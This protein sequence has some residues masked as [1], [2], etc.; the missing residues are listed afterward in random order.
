MPCCKQINTQD[1]MEGKSRV[2]A[3]TTDECRTRKAHKKSYAV[4]HSSSEMIAPLW[5]HGTDSLYKGTNRSYQFLCKRN[6]SFYTSHH[7]LASVE[8]ISS[9]YGF[10]LYFFPYNTC[11]RQCLY[12]SWEKSCWI[13]WSVCRR[14]CFGCRHRLSG[15]PCETVK[16]E[17]SL[18]YCRIPTVRMFQDYICSITHP[19]CR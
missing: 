7:F 2:Y 13:L 4:G 10:L 1:S 5:K 16:R 17:M 18:T 8:A 3:N 14:A 6:Y 12:S 15:L 11:V 19:M 9:S